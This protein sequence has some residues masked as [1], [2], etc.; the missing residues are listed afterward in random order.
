MRTDFMLMA[1]YNKPRLNFEETCNALGIA[2]ATG[3]SQRS[4]GTFP[5]PMAGKGPNLSADIR[6]VALAI[7]RIRE[8]AR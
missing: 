7:D 4:R 1:I 8:T 5:V 2:L 6:D 3:Y